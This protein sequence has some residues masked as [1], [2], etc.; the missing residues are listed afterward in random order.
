RDPHL[1]LV[2]STP[3]RG[4]EQHRTAR[5]RC[6]PC[7]HSAP[8]QP[9]I[10]LPQGRCIGRD[11]SGCNLTGHP[12]RCQARTRCHGVT[13][14][15]RPRV[16]PRRRPPFVAIGCRLPLR[17]PPAQRP[18]KAASTARGCG[19][20]REMLTLAPS[21]RESGGSARLG[22][23]SMRQATI[24]SIAEALG[25][26]A[27]TVSRAFSRPDLVKASVREEVLAKARELGYAP[28]R[29]ARGLATGRTGLY[30]LMAPDIT[31]PFFPPFVRAVQLA[32][33]ARD[34]DILLID[35]ERSAAAEEDLVQRIRPQVDGLI[36]ASPRLPSG[37]LKEM[38]AGVPSVVVNR[39]VRGLPHV[40][41]DNSA[42]LAQAA[43]H[44]YERLEEHTS[45]L[46]SRE[47]LVCRL[48]LEKIKKYTRKR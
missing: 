7:S 47:K 33:G 42:V 5:R 13:V 40:V 14:R 10:G 9:S 26:S 18:S 29:A 36:V 30:G 1:G 28:N 48:L 16:A 6:D 41:C 38:L 34:T 44:L 21:E 4:E 8:H 3:T 27:S 25:V 11:A 46:Q 37:R 24:Y 17:L 45:E 20:R 2:P 15:S 12:G 43:D 35:S 23:R 32:A 39:A 22:G 31:N 19:H